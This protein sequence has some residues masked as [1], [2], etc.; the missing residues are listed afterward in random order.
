[1]TL[2]Q[3]TAAYIAGKPVTFVLNDTCWAEWPSFPTIWY[4]G[5]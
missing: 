3:L 2:A 1:V 4:Y 5:F